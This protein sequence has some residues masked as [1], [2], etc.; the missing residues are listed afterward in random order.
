MQGRHAG[1]AS[2]ETDTVRLTRLKLEKE[3]Y[4]KQCVAG[5]SH[6]ELSSAVKDCTQNHKIFTSC[7][8]RGIEFE[9]S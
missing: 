5:A 7:G 1:L 4:S 6:S 9:E 2:G 8:T 3:R